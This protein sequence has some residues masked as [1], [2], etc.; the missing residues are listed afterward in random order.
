MENVA[1]KTLKGIYVGIKTL[2][3]IYVEK[4]IIKRNS[5][6]KTLDEFFPFVNIQGK[7]NIDSTILFTKLIAFVQ[8]DENTLN[9]FT[10]KL[11]YQPT[12]LFE[13]DV[14]V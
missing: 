8:S 13:D 4:T 5:Q 14:I 9:H 11:T 7:I 2:E 6:V 3:R 10:Y 1:I 12:A